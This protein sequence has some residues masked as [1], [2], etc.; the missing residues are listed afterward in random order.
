[1]R[2]SVFCFVEVAVTLSKHCD[3]GESWKSE[4]EG[5]ATAPREQPASGLF[6]PHIAPRML[7]ISHILSP[8]ISG[9]KN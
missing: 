8:A 9:F 2:L 5:I 6:T 4:A 1:M 7:S 3:S